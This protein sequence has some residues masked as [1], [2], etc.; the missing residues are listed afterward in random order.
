MEQDNQRGPVSR[1]YM[2]PQSADNSVSNYLQD[3][4]RQLSDK[5]REDKVVGY[6]WN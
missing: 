2:S 5:K 3:R 4:Q 1:Y 6:K